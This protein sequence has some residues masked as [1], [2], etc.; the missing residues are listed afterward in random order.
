MILF[1]YMDNY[2]LTVT[3]GGGQNRNVREI[4]R[5]ILLDYLAVPSKRW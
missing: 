2:G 1:L 4:L 3:S 5:V